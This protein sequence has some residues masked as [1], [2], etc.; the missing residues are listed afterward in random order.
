M[1]IWLASGSPRRKQLLEWSGYSCEVK[2]KNI[3]ESVGPNE[4][5][6][7]YVLRMAKEKSALFW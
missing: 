2:P 6:L 4:D 3:D 7:T 5:P 1:N